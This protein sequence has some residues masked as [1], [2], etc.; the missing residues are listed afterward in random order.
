MR[1]EEFAVARLNTML[2][3]AMLLAGDREEARDIVPDV[4]AR[5]LVRWDRIVRIEEPWAYVRRM[6]TNEFISR[7]RRRAVRT[8]PLDDRYDPPAPART[9]PGP[10]DEMWRLLGGLPRQQRAVLVLRRWPPRPW[11][12]RW[13]PWPCR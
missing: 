9:D 5:A 6:L 8:V 4:L 11:W 13:S 1:F 10:A 12:W 7:R 2:R 3:Y